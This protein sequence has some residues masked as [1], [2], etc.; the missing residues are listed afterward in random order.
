MVVVRAHTI[1]VYGRKM[2]PYF[3]ASDL[4]AVI[5][6]IVSLAV[7][8]RFHGIAARQFTLVF[9]GMIACYRLALEVEARWLGMP[10][11]SFLKDSPSPAASAF[12][13]FLLGY[14]AL[15]FVL[16]FWRPTS[17]RPRIGVWSEAQVECVDAAVLSAIWLMTH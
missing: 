12:P 2:H 16:D 7:L 15:R 13:F 10:F 11:R 9:V 3:I 17:A 14:S 4:A 8:G 1:S 5:A 6:L